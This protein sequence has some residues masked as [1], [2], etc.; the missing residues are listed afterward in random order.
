MTDS[1]FAD[2]AAET[3]Q[4]EPFQ[5]RSG[6]FQT[7]PDRS[8]S[9]PDTLSEQKWYTKQAENASFRR[10]VVEKLTIF[11]TLA[12]V[13]ILSLYIGVDHRATACAAVV[14]VAYS[15]AAD[16]LGILHRKLSKVSR[17][18]IGLSAIPILIAI[19]STDGKTAGISTLIVTVLIVISWIGNK[20]WRAAESYEMSRHVLKALQP[21]D[22]TD[23][24]DAC[25]NAW[26]AD[27]A[28]EVV[29]AAAE[30]GAYSCTEIE[31]SVRKAAY[32]IGFCRASAMTRKNRQERMSIEK[33]VAALE[34]ENAFLNQRVEN[35]AVF[36][37]QYDEYVRRLEAAEEQAKRGVRSELRAADVESENRKL[38][39]ENKSLADAN[40]ELIKTADNPLLAEEIAEEMVLKRLKEAADLG[41][42]VRQTA[43]YATVSNRRA[44]EYLTDYYEKHPDKKPEKNK[45]GK[46]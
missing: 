32:T 39:A 30:M 3:V 35:L 1:L 37:D 11:F 14:L 16:P 25:L 13:V 28:R 26:Q 27:G 29:A 10:W 20:H 40:D 33:K 24:R 31:W 12:V 4:N 9:V 21:D 43:A 41:L 18:M 6:V 36:A 15:V 42:S 38:K 45:G 17:R 2:N 23:H 46:K 5:T 34:S 44:Y 8:E 7:V 22:N 19:I